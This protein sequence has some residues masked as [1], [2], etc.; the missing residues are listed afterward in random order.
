MSQRE[1]EVL[2]LLV[3]GLTPNQIAKKLFLSVATVRN[4]LK[5][6]YRKADAHSQDELVAW[7][8]Q[9]RQ[10]HAVGE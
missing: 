9:G 2:G 3:D 1:W 4:H 10:V 8:K 5:T 6:M 7:Y